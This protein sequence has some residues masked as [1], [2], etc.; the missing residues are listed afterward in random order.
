MDL[1]EPVNEDWT[2]RDYYLAY[3]LIILLILFL[4]ATHFWMGPTIG[5]TS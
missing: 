1:F 5:V 4:V 3:A 2:K